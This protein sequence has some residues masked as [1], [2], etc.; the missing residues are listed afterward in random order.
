MSLFPN[1]EAY[2]KGTDEPGKTLGFVDLC[3]TK[4]FVGHYLDD[5]SDGM[6]ALLTRL[7]TSF[8]SALANVAKESP[9]VDVIQASDG[10]FLIG[11]PNQVLES[12][13]KVFLYTPSFFKPSKVSLIPMRAALANG[14]IRV[15]EGESLKELTNLRTF[16]FWGPAFVKTYLMEK[17]KEAKG[18]HIFI[19]E[20][21]AN[22]LDEDTCKSVLREAPVDTVSVSTKDEES[23]Y[24]V[25]W[26]S[27]I[28]KLTFDGT[29][30][31]EAA[32]EI[33]NFDAKLIAH[34]SAIAETWVK[35]NDQHFQIYGQSILDLK[36][37]LE[38]RL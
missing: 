14:L 24:K 38:N 28:P 29:Q 13:V 5:E 7:I 17:T 12:M 15:E 37:D 1:I 34:L 22:Q 2:L 36:E 6:Q 31:S 23:F 19:S 21:V 35:G 18:I 16:P 10:A 4:A 20:S 33:E 25:N 3:G 26:I 11:E 8:G 32:T 30:L 27:L 9:D